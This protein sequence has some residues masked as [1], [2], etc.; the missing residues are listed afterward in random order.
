MLIEDP[1]LHLRGVHRQDPPDERVAE[2]EDDLDRLERL[3]RADDAREHTEDTGLSAARRQL[4]GRRLR[5]HVAIGGTLEG[6]EHAHHALEAEDRAVHDGDAELH[7]RVVQH[8]AR[9]E[10]V[11]AIDDDVVAGDDVDDVLG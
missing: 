1:E 11:G 2:T 5:H 7:A 10:V 9:R 8:V 3:D 6:M 4:G